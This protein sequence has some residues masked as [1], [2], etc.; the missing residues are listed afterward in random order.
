MIQVNGKVLIPDE[1]LDEIAGRRFRTPLTPLDGDESTLSGSSSKRSSAS[2][3][4]SR[5]N[6]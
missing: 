6:A 5:R 2:R 3:W 4:A 1:P